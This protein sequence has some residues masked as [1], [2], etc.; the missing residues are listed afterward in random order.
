MNIDQPASSDDQS[1]ASRYERARVL[2]QAAYTNAL[3][4]NSCLYPKWIDQSDSL[5][6]AREIRTGGSTRGKEYR[7]VNANAATNELAFDHQVLAEAL[8]QA[9]G[10]SVD[11]QN[12]PIGQ[13]EVNAFPSELTFKAFGQHW[14]FDRSLNRCEVMPRHP[15]HWLVS[16]N[17]KLAVFLQD[18]NLW[19]VD[20]ET[21]EQR[22]LT[23]D[24]ERHYAYASVPERM[25]IVSGLNPPISPTP[26]ALWSPDS[27]QLFTVQTDERTLP[28]LPVT[29]YVPEDGRVR[30]SS[31]EVRYALPGDPQVAEYRLLVVDIDTDRATEIPCHRVPDIGVR[32]LIQRQRVWW[33]ADS[34]FTYIVDIGRGEQHL[35]LLAYD[36]LVDKIH[37]L[38]E[39]TA[40]T[41]ID[42]NGFNDEIASFMPLPDS[43]ELIWWSERSGWAHLYLYDL[44]TGALKRPLTQGKWLVRELIG[45][46]AAQ[47]DVFIQAAGRVADRDPYYR[48]ICRVNIDTG[49]IVS[50][51][52]SDHDYFIHKPGT[53]NHRAM[54]WCGQDLTGVSGLAPSARYFVTTRT[55]VDEAPRS[56]LRDR[57]GTLIMSLEQADIADL[58]EGW[59]WPEPVKLQAADG[60][61]ELYGVVFRPSHFDPQKQYPV[62]DYAQTHAFIAIAP[63]GSF[64]S[65]GISSA[66]YYY[67]AAAW[68]ELGFI[69]VIIDGRGTTYRDRAFH[70]ESYACSHTAS[71]LEDHIAGIRQLAERYPYMDID[72]VGITGPGGCNAPAY[73]LLA[74]PDF[75]QVGAA[76]SIYDPRLTHGMDTYEGNPG[77]GNFEHAVL[78]NLADQLTGKLLLVHGMLD[79]FFHTAGMLQLVD[80][81][82]RANKPF[83]MLVLPNGGHMW[84]GGYQLC[85][86]WNYMVKHLQGE[87]PPVGFKLKTGGEFLAGQL[88]G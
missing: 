68:A 28:S 53:F 81:L 51:A 48:E 37:C 55:R 49:E 45:F 75:Y 86:A 19:I 46:D 29:Q 27:K 62:I 33:S 23:T 38:F 21:S 15:E 82:A 83:D 73:G 40:S 85:Q 24:G 58:P 43:D 61:T 78:G 25:D 72:R 66:A 47:R 35:Q 42:L 50:L 1:V 20:L 36:T 31:A 22:P 65:T 39:E 3:A 10:Q 59:Q 26:E 87:E 8:S 60:K 5:V 57:N 9:S 71:N 76:C 64:G 30:P 79:N 18:Y 63:K 17:G 84:A 52:S 13:L 12:L 74:Y 80:A 11:P 6:Y 41:Y 70:D 16:P 32:S 88:G 14:R 69:V 44:K 54:G 56:E 4:L 2:E 7:L 77:S 34:R 67:R